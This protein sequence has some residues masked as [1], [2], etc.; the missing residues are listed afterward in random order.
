MMYF[1]DFEN[2]GTTGLEGLETLTGRD[3]VVLFVSDHTTEK[4]MLK[5]LSETKA[6]IRIEYVSTT[7]KNAMDF[8]LISSVGA[9]IAK[10][11]KNL[12]IVSGDKGYDAARTFWNE[13][14]ISVRSL[15]SISGKL[16]KQETPVSALPAVKSEPVKKA[17]KNASTD[18]GQFLKKH[19]GD[20]VAKKE[21]Q[22]LRK[23]L[24]N[25]DADACMDAFTKLQISSNEASE[26]ERFL[27]NSGIRKVKSPN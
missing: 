9:E 22:N 23:V 14:G 11:K 10:G 7:A 12:C 17:P 1:V 21:R 6:R 27:I 16:Q 19:F 3:C 15:S 4:G 26:T 25:K 8:C 2:V 20:R 24:I 5:R 18:L 13:R